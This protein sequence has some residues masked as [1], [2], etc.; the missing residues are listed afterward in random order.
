MRQGL[1]S[2]NSKH[3]TFDDGSLNFKYFNVKKGHYWSK[4]ENERL[5]EGVLRFGATD[6]KSIR[7][8][9]FRNAHSGGS[10][11]ETE[12]RLR[13]CRLLKC[14]DLSPYEGRRFASR[15]EILEIARRNKEE[16]VVTKRVCGGIL[17]NPPSGSAATGAGRDEDDG[18]II[19]SL[20]NKKKQESGAVANTGATPV[21]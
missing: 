10:W 11:S 21:K 12:I 13:V 1:S 7:K 9:C 2:E 3:I 19:S 8:E 5:M 4:E 16:A 6:F 15:E 18:G 14:Y 17:Y 20:F